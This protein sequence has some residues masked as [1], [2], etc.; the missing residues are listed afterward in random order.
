VP[1]RTVGYCVA[2]KHGPRE[3]LMR[4]MAHSRWHLR[5]SSREVG[6]QCGW[7][8]ACGKPA[9]LRFLLENRQ[10]VVGGRLLTRAKVR[11][12]RARDVGLGVSG[13]FRAAR[14]RAEVPPFA[15]AA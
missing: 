3:D 10:D 8:E 12:P 13:A 15:V 6:Y 11:A 1:A 14:Q 4:G 9:V 2:V 5:M 7:R